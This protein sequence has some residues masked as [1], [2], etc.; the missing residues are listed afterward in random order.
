MLI[1]VLVSGLLLVIVALGVFA[2]FDGASATSGTIKAR[3]MASGVA[4]QDQERMRAFKLALLSNYRETRS[5]TIAGVPYKVVSRG[6]WISDASGSTACGSASARADYLKISSTV[7]WPAMVGAKPIKAESLVAAPNGS[8][9]PSQGSLGVTVRDGSGTGVGGVPVSLSG[10][11][12]RT[13]V[14]DDFGCVLY[15]FLPAGNYTVTLAAPGYV[16]RQGSNTVTKSVSVIGEA[17]NNVSLEYDRAGS[18]DIRFDTKVGAAA[19]Q[20]ANWD[21]ATIS[22][23]GLNPPG[24]R[25]FGTAGVSKATLAAGGLFPFNDPYAVYAGNCGNANPSVYGHTPAFVTVAAGT[26]YGAT[27]RLPALNLDV[28]RAGAPLAAARVRVTPKVIGCAGVLT[29]ATNAAGVLPAPGVPYGAYDVCADDGTRRAV[30][31]NVFN[32]DPNGTAPV[33][34]NVPNTG[35]TGTCA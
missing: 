21:T 23:S 22:H 5:Q 12:A 20:P 9:G 15:A 33:A 1:E 2:G 26:G 29:F 17:T 3:A 11:A 32:T 25:L 13:D 18:I 28:R 6:D 24:T 27:V 14:T 4:Q 8:F 31:Q 35:A 30:V 10:T 7:T 34:L 16:D 19:P